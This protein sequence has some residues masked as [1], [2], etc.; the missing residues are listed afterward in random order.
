MRSIFFP[1]IPIVEMIAG[2]CQ[3]TLWLPLAVALPG[4]LLWLSWVQL[5]SWWQRIIAAV[6]SVFILLWVIFAVNEFFRWMIIL[7]A[8]LLFGV[9]QL[10]R[11]KRHLYANILLF[12]LAWLG[13][14]LHYRGQLLPNLPRFSST[15]ATLTILDYNILV[16]QRGTQRNQ[17]FELIASEKP[18]LIF[19]QEINSGDRKLFREKMG[20]LYPHQLWADRREYYNGGAILSKF[21]IKEAR[22]VDLSTH[23]LPGHTNLNHAVIN[24]RGRDI[25]LLNCHLYPSGHAFIQLLFGRRSLGS[26]IDHT[27]SAFLRRMDEAEQLA[28]ITRKI[29]APVIMAGDFNDTPNSPIYRLFQ[30]QL[31]NAFAARGWGMGTTFGYHSL[32]QSVSPHWRGLLFDFLRI[33]HVFVS[34]HFRVEQARVLPVAASDHRPLLVCVRWRH[35]PN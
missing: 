34:S 20:A 3:D 30:Q 18:D 23:H 19:I 12:V 2:L 16:G 27:R 32:K 9:I 4:Y 5:S 11:Q 14:V 17:V 35:N 24:W 13:V 22:N 1:R 7:V 8:F 15:E 29:Q 31:Q 25:H 21:P 28:A 33:D 6:F 26:F 10:V